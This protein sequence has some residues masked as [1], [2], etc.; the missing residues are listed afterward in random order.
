MTLK[1]RL[2]K[3]KITFA[4]IDTGT[5]IPKELLKNIFKCFIQGDLS[6]ARKF[7]GVGLGLSIARAYATIINGLVWVESVFG[8]GS[9]FYCEIPL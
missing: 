7:E 8:E 1:T 5:G 9:S 6:Y 4:V 3:N 2:T